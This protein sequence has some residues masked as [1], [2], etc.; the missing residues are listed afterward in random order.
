[1]IIN[2]EDDFLKDREREV[3]LLFVDNETNHELYRPLEHWKPLFQFPYRVFHA[4]Y[5]GEP[6]DPTDYTHI[7][8]SGSLSSTL[9][10]QPWMLALEE[11]IR[12]AVASGRVFLGSCFGHQILARALFGRDAVRRRAEPEIGWPTLTACRDSSFF[13][14]RGDKLH[15]FLYHNDEVL[16]KASPGVD[17]LLESAACANLAFKLRDYPV[18]G[19]QPHFEIGIVQGLA[20][21]ADLLPQG[22]EPW[23]VFINDP[24]REPRDPGYIA[25]IMREFAAQQPLD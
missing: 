14:K 6:P 22:K 9:E 19:L 7:L 20:F 3:K 2:V 15:G 4:P 21:L 25:R 12:Q 10:E 18:W 11:Y 17:I 13:G 5:D 24:A 8:L 23:T 16:L 1:M